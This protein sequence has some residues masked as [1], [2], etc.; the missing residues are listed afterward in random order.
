MVFRGVL[1]GY[2]LGSAYKRRSLRRDA[3]RDSGTDTYNLKLGYP[4]PIPIHLD[5]DGRIQYSVDVLNGP[6]VDCVLMDDR[7]FAYY[8]DGLECECYERGTVYCATAAE[9]SFQ[10]SAGQYTLMV[11][12][13]PEASEEITIPGDSCVEFA[14]SIDAT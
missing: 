4:E 5:T 3:L 10:L 14:Y 9:I 12:Q 7:N 8:T 1:V 11:R 6:P 2:L 13:A